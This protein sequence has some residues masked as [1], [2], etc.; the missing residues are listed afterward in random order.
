MSFMGGKRSISGDYF[1]SIFFLNQKLIFRNIFHFF[2][3]LHA[4]SKGKIRVLAASI[5]IGIPIVNIE[6][7]R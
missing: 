1:P 7:F 3:L 4:R 5:S 2:H 6:D